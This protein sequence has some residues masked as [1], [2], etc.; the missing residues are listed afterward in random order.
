MSLNFNFHMVSFKENRGF[1]LFEF[2]I[3]TVIM[4]VLAAIIISNFI[5]LQKKSNLDSSIKEFAGVLRL[6]QN[7][8]LLSKDGN[9][10][11]V[12]IDPQFSNKYVLFKGIS[13]SARDTSA[14][15]I[16]FLPNTM[17]FI[18]IGGSSIIFDK[19]T[20]EVQGGPY[21]VS[22]R[23]KA[24]TSQIKTVYVTNSGTIS[25]NQPI[26][27]SDANRIQ[28]SRHVQFNY[29]R[30]I[31]TSTENIILTFNSGAG[32]AT[33]KIIPIN[34]YLVAGELQWQG[35]VNVGGV[36]QIVGI[37]THW[38]NNPDTLFSVRRDRRYNNNSLVITISGDNSGSL[39][40][41]SADGIVTTHSSIYVSSFAW[42]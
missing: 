12:Y 5:L 23:L 3:V 9:P 33:T 14:D 2:M 1:T 21:S 16:Y 39:V 26:T 7:N 10:Y 4:S 35:T 28:D 19:L 31:N 37:N 42:Q 32:G 24:D 13:Y 15:Q 6:A 41:Y 40:Q 36:D 27:P 34:A 17:E 22:V 18:I 11:G 8:A 25:F 30:I 29:S 38:L 20:G